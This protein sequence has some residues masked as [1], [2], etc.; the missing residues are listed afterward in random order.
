MK[1]EKYKEDKKKLSE[2][3]NFDLIIEEKLEIPFYIF[4]TLDN[5]SCKIIY[6]SEYTY[7]DVI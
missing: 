7:M 6:F 2:H 4:K 3:L 5:N 1:F